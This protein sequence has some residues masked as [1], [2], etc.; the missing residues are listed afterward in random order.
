MPISGVTVQVFNVDNGVGPIIS[1]PTNGDG[2]YQVII[3]GDQIPGLWMVQILENG[4]PVSEAMGHRL[5][6]ECLNGAQELKADW[7]RTE[8]QLN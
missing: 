5:G 8:L 2:I 4:Q 1:N 7:Q 6:G 3:N